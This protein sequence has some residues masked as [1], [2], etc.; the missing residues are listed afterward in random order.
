MVGAHCIKKLVDLSDGQLSQKEAA[1]L[2]KDLDAHG[3]RNHLQ[4]KQYD[5]AV[6]EEAQRINEQIQR[7]A[8][9]ERRNLAI[10]LKVRAGLRADIDRYLESGMTLRR[11][12]QTVLVGSNANVRGSRYSVQARQKAAT[13]QYLDG[14]LSELQGGEYMALLNNKEFQPYIAR[15]LWALS[16]GEGGVT[17]RAEALEIARIIRKYQEAARV[18]M[19][20]AGADIGKVPGYISKQTHDAARIRKAG[21][22]KWKKDI[23]PRL[24][25]DTFEG[26]RDREAFLQSVYEGLIS[27]VHLKP[28]T[29]S[30][31][32]FEF[33]G[34]AN[35]A[36]K[37]SGERVLHFKKADDWLAY[38]EQYGTRN[39]VDSI[40]VEAEYNGRTIGLLDGLGTNPQSMLDN[41][42]KEYK[43]KNRANDEVM[44]RYSDKALDSF[45][46]NIDGSV[47]VADNIHLASIMSTVRA[48]QSMAK[49]GGAVISAVPDIAIMAD[50]LREHGQGF[51]ESHVNALKGAFQGRGSAEKREIA[52]LI[53]VGTD[54][55]IGAINLRFDATDNLP[56][57]MAKMQRLFFKLNGLQWWTDTLKI[58]AGMQFAHRLGQLQSKTFDELIPTERRMLEAYGM[59]EADWN[60]L[61]TLELQEV[62]GKK[63]LTPDVVKDKALRSKLQAY[64]RDGTDFAVITTD[65]REQSILNQGL[66]RGTIMGE[67]VRTMMQFKAFPT[68][69]I[70]KVIGRKLYSQGKADIQGLFL[71]IAE[72]TAMGYVAMS[73]KDV[74][75][76]KEPR[77]VD[78]TATWTAA[79]L[80]GGG[81]GIFGDF[82]FGEYN[83][84]GRS[85][86]QTLAGPT[87]GTL[88]D[89]A[90]VYASAKEGQDVSSSA[91][92]SALSN[93][94][95]ANL[96]YLRT[97]ANYLFLHQ[98]QESMNPGYLRRMERRAR[99][100]NNQEYIFPPSQYAR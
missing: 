69:V 27:G 57:G 78:E 41:I 71:L 88:D 59:T 99:K 72:M 1:E 49:L 76:G 60:V 25:E 8:A 97:A 21:Y 18:R 51:L 30:G 67:A 50:V 20:E 73:A 24:R 84:F 36:K 9:I 17:G 39:F 40:I 96:F 83:R 10:N 100:E 38:N 26:V 48:V 85:F 7:A 11:A 61:R 42:R 55:I 19:N 64:Y 75:K 28:A 45:M 16:E 79:M 70:T 82:L 95:F 22:D 29:E 89:V 90:R 31:K 80:Q 46:A 5:D 37:K 15:E 74:L 62:D 47:F 34:P 86:T 56:G 91:L 14:M 68:A 66:A 94:P 44:R 65:A 53:G 4:G 12:M 23:L 43:Q 92:N 77:S 6:M 58:A 98:I 63:Y 2:L 54:G 81:I 13:A 93:T 33:T 52:S 35:L 3:R 87:A 32:L